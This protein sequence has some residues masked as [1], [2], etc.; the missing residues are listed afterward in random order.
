MRILKVTQAYYPFEERGGPAVKVRSIARLM[1][2]Q[3][4]KIAVVTADLGFSPAQARAAGASRVPGGWRAVAV[5]VEAV[6]LTTRFHYRNLTV[7]PGILSFCR[8]RLR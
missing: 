5:G 3:G 7:N 1:A 2:G 4:H 6:Y 8:R